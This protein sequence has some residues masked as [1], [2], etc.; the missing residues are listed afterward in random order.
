MKKSAIPAV[1]I[2]GLIGAVAVVPASADSTLY[3]NPGPGTYTTNGWGVP[4]SDSFTLS[5]NST[6]TGANL[7]LWFNAGDS[8]VS[9]TWQIDSSFTYFDSSTSLES[10]TSPVV[11]STSEGT[12]DGYPVYQVSIAIPS[13]ALDAGTTY[14]LEL[15]NVGSTLGIGGFWDE[16]DGPSIA[17]NGDVGSISAFYDNGS[18]GSETFQILG[19]PDSVTPEPSNFLLLG[20]GLAG[21]AGLIKRKLRA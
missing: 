8:P 1:L 3:S 12:A 7:T 17:Y 9:V 2:L 21:L 15:D 10:G 18:S 5:Q 14:W 13:L 20:S 16:S 19:S 4:T 11:S 6:V